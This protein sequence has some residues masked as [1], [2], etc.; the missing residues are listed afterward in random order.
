MA[1][2][3]KQYCAMD[4]DELL[5][6]FE[7]EM[8]LA[9]EGERLE[10]L[11]KDQ[12]EYDAF[13]QEHNRFN[14]KKGDLASYKG[15]CYLGI[16]AGSTTTKLALV[17][18]DGSLLWRFYDNNNGSPLKTSIRA[19]GELKKVMPKTA[20]I[21]GSC[22]TGYGEALIKAAFNLDH[23]EVETMA[24]YYA[25]AFFEPDVDCILDIGGTG[26]EMYQDQKQR[27]G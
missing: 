20:K 19:M 3:S 7:S 5:G 6:Y 1:L 17:G 4:F 22:S 8:H 27:R 12:A 14:V 13:I 23:G 18:E 26:Y 10:P 25:A 24:H 16:D 21:A 9:V 2:N 15:K 11:F